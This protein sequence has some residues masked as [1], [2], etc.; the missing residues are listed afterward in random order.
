[1]YCN[2]CGEKIADGSKFCGNCGASAEIKENTTS[3]HPDNSVG[4]G[5]IVV[6]SDQRDTISPEQQE[7]WQQWMAFARSVYNEY[8]AGGVYTG[9]EVPL[10]IA[11]LF[12]RNEK[13]IAKAPFQEYVFTGIGD[14]TINVSPIYT[15]NA[16][17]AAG[18]LIGTLYAKNKAQKLAEVKWHP[19]GAGEIVVTDFGIYIFYMDGKMVDFTYDSFHGAQMTAWDNI[20]ID[21]TNKADGST[22]KLAFSTPVAALIFAMWCFNVY[23][24]HPQLKGVL[25]L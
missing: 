16:Y 2:Q 11:P 18:Q 17:L 1:M 15:S 25:Q 24:Q 14:G 12:N 5:D 3:A 23:P 9:V 8:T 7:E 6:Q 13:R 19:T 10:P 4:A 21:G 20:E 22:L